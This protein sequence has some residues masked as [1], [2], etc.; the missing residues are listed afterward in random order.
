MGNRFSLPELSQEN[1]D[2][3]PPDQANF[4]GVLAVGGDLSVNRLARAYRD[5]IFPWYSEGEPIQWWSPNPRFVL[6][7]DEWKVSKSMN[8]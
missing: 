6:F 7:P 3:P 2:F 4:W 8:R 1:L 5:G